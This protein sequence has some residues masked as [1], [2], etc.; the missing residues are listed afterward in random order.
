MEE[1]KIGRP[2]FTN[3]ELVSLSVPIVIES[4]LAIITGMA[5]STMV[6]SAGEAAVSGISLVDQL[7]IVLAVLFSSVAS[8]GVVVTAQYIGN[9]DFQKAKSS[10]RQLLYGATA[11]ALLL[12]LGAIGLIPQ[13]LHLV[14]GELEPA[15]ME[16]ATAY[17]F[18]ALL[19]M[20][21][22][23]IASSCTALLRTMSHSKL[24]LFLALC[25][26]ILNIA[27]NAILIYGFDMGAAGAAIATS[28]SRVVWA[29]VSMI[30]MHNK[31]L[32]VYFEK[33]L[34][35]RMD[36]DVMRRVMKVGFANGLENGLFQMGKLLV[37]RLI[38]TF[39][40]VYIAA[41]YVASTLCNIGWTIAG[42][43][44]TV[45]LTVVGQCIGAGETGQAKAYTKKFLWLSHGMVIVLFGLVF[46]LR[47]QLVL[48]FDFGP[49]ALEVCAYYTGVAA[50]LTIC[51]FYGSAFLPVAAFRSAGDVR[52]A[53]V[54]A[55]GSMFTFRVGLSF[56]L[57]Y[58]FELGLL[59]VWIGMWADWTFRSIVNTIHFRRGKWLTKRLI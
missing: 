18:Y 57:S 27:G 59:S 28:I 50:L 26:N 36:W 48:L 44:G 35:F 47:N 54:L 15:V 32:P 58:L 9:Q 51:A 43:L 52:Y 17:F 23:A 39:G 4:V 45:L 46:L 5:D 42:S 37:A 30:I 34:S 2:M 40:T 13:I 29:V 1:R 11:I 38:S 25:A 22:L 53:V 49:E 33:L 16:N 19:G 7:F 20:P 41:N 3:R 8:G 55:V 21:F 10:A 12:S 56:L 14:Y 24:A 31:G 6:S